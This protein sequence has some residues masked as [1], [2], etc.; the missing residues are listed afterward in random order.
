MVV[1]ATIVGDDQ[2][3]GGFGKA[4]RVAIAQGDGED[5]QISRVDVRWDLQHDQVA[6]GLHHA[7][8]ARFLREQGVEV[9]VTG[10]M[11]D[12]MVRMLDSM[13]IKVFSGEGPLQDVLRATA[14]ESGAQ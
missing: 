8:I 1:C 12:G 5:W 2:V 14:A 9:V 13:K 6:D 4:Q 7:Q 11:G 10:H 3:G